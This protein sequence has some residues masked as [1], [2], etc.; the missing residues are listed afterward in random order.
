MTDLEKIHETIN[1]YAEGGTFGQPETVAKAFH[2]TAYMKFMKGE[3][4][5][6]IPIQKYFSDYI[7]GGVTQERVVTINSID[8]TGNASA[9]KLTIDYTTHQF[10][11]YFNM[12][13]I[14]NRWLIVSKI[15]FR[16]NKLE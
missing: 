14:D 8:I 4:L 10:I 11:D 7:K 3:E 1:F 16:I 12:L 15:F 9:V 13:K 6:D 2:P 5:V